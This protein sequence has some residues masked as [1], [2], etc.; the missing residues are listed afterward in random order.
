MSIISDSVEVV[1]GA[2][3][4][5]VEGSDEVSC[6]VGVTIPVIVIWQESQ[7]GRVGSLG[8]LLGARGV[9]SWSSLSLCIWH[10]DGF[11]LLH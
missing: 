4:S 3:D 10:G 7:G 1:E 9:G 2:C 6:P 8:S 5:G 11:V